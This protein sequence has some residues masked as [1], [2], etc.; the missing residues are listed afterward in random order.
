MDA[1]T[2][3]P[4]LLYADLLHELHDLIGAKR[5]ESAEADALAARMDAAWQAM[6]AGDRES[7]RGIC[8]SLYGWEGPSAVRSGS[9]PEPRWQTAERTAHALAD[10]LDAGHAPGSPAVAAVEEEL[11][12]H[13][14]TLTEDQKKRVR[15]IAADRNEARRVRQLSQNGTVEPKGPPCP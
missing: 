3:D 10:L 1:I 11:E 4:S 14:Y 12:G 2:S 8:R 6:S 15:R 5:G 13:W 7:M 9:R